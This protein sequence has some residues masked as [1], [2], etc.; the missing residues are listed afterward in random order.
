MHQGLLRPEYKEGL[1]QDY[2]SYR[3]TYPSVGLGLQMGPVG[4]GIGL[5]AFA[6]PS[7]DLVAGME[8][9]VHLY[10][11]R[12]LAKRSVQPFAVLSLGSA[13]GEDIEG[14]GLL[15]Y[16]AGM[17]WRLGSR[18]AAQALVRRLRFSYY[19]DV[20]LKSTLTHIGIGLKL[21]LL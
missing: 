15:G 2:G 7:V 9:S 4:I 5:Y 11:L 20:A 16:G 14:G 8:A 17:E 1:Q 18:L 10:P 6:P 13:G 3:T 21:R 19:E 12:L